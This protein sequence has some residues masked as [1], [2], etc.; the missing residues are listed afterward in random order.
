MVSFRTGLGFPRVPHKGLCPTGYSS[1][2]K[3]ENNPEYPTE[4][5]FYAAFLQNPT[6]ISIGAIEATRQKQIVD[7]A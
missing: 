7:R 4:K 1:P 2:I 3:Y 6:N 5:A